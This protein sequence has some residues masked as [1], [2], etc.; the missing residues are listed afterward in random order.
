MMR[1]AFRGLLCVGLV[2]TV[3][4]CPAA[5]Q[6]STNPNALLIFHN[7]TGPMCTAALG[8]LAR[9]RTDHPDLVVEEHLTTDAAGLALLGQL[10]L[11]YAES[12]GVST[13]FGYLPIIFFKGQAFSGFN[14]GI[15]QSLE[16]LIESMNTPS[17]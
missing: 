9:M 7:G 14:D 16:G 10:R 11:Q 17:S 3:C 1:T 15:Q 5:V 13:A 12:Q 8:W 4:G 6:D 2:T